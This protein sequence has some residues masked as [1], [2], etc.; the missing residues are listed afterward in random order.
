MSK[1]QKSTWTT[2]HLG[3]IVNPTSS[4]GKAKKMWPEI[5]KELKKNFKKISFYFTERKRDGFVKSRKLIEEG[6]NT[7]LVIS[8]DGVINEVANEIIKSQKKIALAIIPIGTGSDTAKPIYKMMQD[9]L[10]I[11]DFIR[12]IKKGDLQVY[13]VGK[14]KYY[15]TK[16]LDTRVERYF[17]N[18]ASVGITAYISSKVNKSSKKLGAM[19]YAW[20]C[21]Q[22]TTSYS[23]PP[24]LWTVFDRKDFPKVENKKNGKVEKEKEIEIEIQEEEEEEEKEEEGVK[25]EQEEEEEKEK[26]KEKTNL[27]GSHWGM[28]EK[29]NISPT[30]K[31]KIAFFAMGIGRFFGGGMMVCPKSI[32]NDGY[33][34]CCVAPSVS[35]KE[36]IQIMI[37]LRSGSHLKL[38]GISYTRGKGVKLE[39]PKSIWKLSEKKRKKE[40][41][42]YQIE[43]EGE[44]VGFLP[45]K[46]EVVPKALNVIVYKIE[47]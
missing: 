35:L 13:D 25:E 37:K 1:N 40:L 11:N 8:G 31:K 39:L 46:F 38:D 47:N 24:T 30:Q 2:T 14:A 44:D 43:L 5:L 3:V 6:C 22:T 7:I 45:A 42:N 9:K 18:I 26:E 28:E 33:F 15:T 21:L 4:K 27:I 32:V 10:K 34:D 16:A 12:I 36:T 29:Y 23:F 41:D 19:S 20:S 17:V